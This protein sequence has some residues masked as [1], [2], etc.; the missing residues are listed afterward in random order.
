MS[1]HLH[2]HPTV[3][4]ETYE[5]VK[6]ASDANAQLFADLARRHHALLATRARAAMSR[7]RR[8]RLVELHAL[9]SISDE[10]KSGEMRQV[11]SVGE[12]DR[13]DNALELAETRLEQYVGV[14]IALYTIP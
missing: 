13:L 3:A 10:A 11:W 7:A 1:R 5:A 9:R 14:S 8:R 4:A 6:T 2:W 12:V